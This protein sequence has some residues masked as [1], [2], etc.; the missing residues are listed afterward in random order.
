[1]LLAGMLG[2]FVWRPAGPSAVRG[3]ID[4]DTPTSV[5]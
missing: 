5:A 4:T 3:H 1:M 2:S